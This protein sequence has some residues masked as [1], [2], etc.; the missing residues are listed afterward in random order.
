MLTFALIVLPFGFLALVT[1]LVV[2]HR[3]EPA[4]ISVVLSLA[5]LWS[6]SVPVRHS[7]SSTASIAYLFLPSAAA[8]VGALGA[9][10]GL[11][12]KVRSMSV[13]ITG[14]MCGIAAIGLIVWVGR[15]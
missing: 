6:G 9:A 10:F 3:Y 1:M 8:V 14:T 2:R 15:G 4:A 12:R 7:H 5:A 11:A 13:R